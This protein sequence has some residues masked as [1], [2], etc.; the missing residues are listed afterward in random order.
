LGSLAGPD[1]MGGAM[2]W[3]NVK[4]P[5]SVQEKVDEH[6]RWANKA[7]D[8]ALPPEDRGEIH[9]L[10]AVL[11]ERNADRPLRVGVFGQ[12]SSGK[13]TLLN[14]LLGAGLLP[15]AA[16]VTT[17]VATRLWPA[18]SDLLSVTLHKGGSALHF[19]SGQFTT[20]YRSI[21]DSAEPSDIRAVL[22]EIMRSRRAAKSIDR[23]DVGL[24]GAV[25]G[26][27]VVVIDTPGFNA[28][29]AGHREVAERVAAE[30]D[31]A[32]VLIPANEPGAM[33]LGQFLHEVLGD[34]HDRCVF[35]LTKF[36][37]VAA[38]ER[39]GLQEYVVSWLEQQGFP[40]A[41]VLRAD[42]TDIAV[43]AR[44]G[45]QSGAD[46]E[47][48][49]AAALAE[50]RDI[51]ERLRNLAADRRQHLIEAT[52]EVV[53]GRL[54]NGVT[55]SVDERRATLEGMRAR[56][57]GVQIVDLDDFLEQWRQDMA[58]E[59]SQSARRSV[60]RESAAY[61]PD[62]ELAAARDRAVEEIGSRN[63]VTAIV[64]ELLAETE[65]VL[66]DWTERALR[67]AVDNS[68][69]DLVK[70]ANRLKRTFTDQYADLAGLTGADPRPPRFE[71]SLPPVA[72]PYIDLTTAFEPLLGAGKDL[73]TTAY[74]KSGG[75]AA[76]G[77]A[78]GTAVFPGIGTLIGA[79]AGW[80]AG[81]GRSKQKEKL[82]SYA[83]EVHSDSLEVARDAIKRSE[84]ALRAVLNDAVRALVTQYKTSA[85][86]V[87]T[88]LTAD[89][90]ARV[91]ALDA[92]LREVLG[93]LAEAG[94][95]HRALANHG[96]RSE[97]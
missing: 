28:T 50:T 71:R 77:A 88:R 46:S 80:M 92:D 29:D 91:A 3:N 74:W 26:P 81:S 40:Q 76:V 82:R 49:T 21:T 54:L 96:L 47:I 34:L 65:K 97:A 17:G 4:K 79:A 94:G 73:Q 57:G 30:A 25:L 24:A 38:A 5:F 93:V 2:E 86:P 14:A 32:I 6:I 87:I 11:A 58:D 10:C 15:S 84:P 13:S 37:Q 39:M 1:L 41:L 51:A 63:D 67:R 90:Q 48:S 70:H 75:G 69:E 59:V 61:G 36:R 52:L 33:S 55:Q 83:E 42:A 62:S 31:L 20:W 95:R 66:I 53:L 8:S 78:L 85:G 7:A 9:R 23:I 12:F 18:E 19:G 64:A 35:V 68:A 16:R 45:H 60:V 22:R 43:A 27:G 44:D 89:Y 72:L 56:L